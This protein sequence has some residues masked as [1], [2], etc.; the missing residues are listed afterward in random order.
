V[1][2]NALVPLNED[3][4]NVKARQLESGGEADGTTTDNDDGL[5]R[6][7]GLGAGLDGH[8]D[9]DVAMVMVMARSLKLMLVLML[10]LRRLLLLDCSTWSDHHLRSVVIYPPDLALRSNKRP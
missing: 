1:P 4:G 3:D 2:R 5:G 9:C 8:G 7:R 6:R 10:M